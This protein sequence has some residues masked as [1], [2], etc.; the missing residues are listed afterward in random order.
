MKA[1]TLISIVVSVA[2]IA[3]LLFGIVSVWH[4]VIHTQRQLNVSHV[5]QQAA[6]T[7]VFPVVHSH[8]LVDRDGNSK[9][10]LLHRVTGPL[11]NVPFHWVDLIAIDPPD[12]HLRCRVD[13]EQV[14]IESQPQ[15]FYALDDLPPR[16]SKISS[17][18]MIPSAP[19][20]KWEALIG[21]IPPQE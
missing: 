14:E 1:R 4:R 13:G 15:V 20:A 21:P 18:T 10:I 12:R 6:N 19:Q 11:K 9:I 7:S 3:T 16:S 5:S 2:F 17:D 8:T